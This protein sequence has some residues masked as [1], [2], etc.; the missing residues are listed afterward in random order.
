[1]RPEE[2]VPAAERTYADD[3]VD[4]T[5]VR[6]EVERMAQAAAEWLNKRQMTARTVTLKVRYSD[7][8]TVTRSHS[9]P[10]TCDRAAI[11]MRAL[12]LLQKTDA[13]ARPVQAAGCER[14]Q[15]RRHAAGVADAVGPAPVQLQR[16]D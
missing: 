2:V 11:V 13:G 16:F 12:E 5:R 15:F 6:A 14:P 1:M 3:I 8:S 7:F 4:A 10:A 9:A